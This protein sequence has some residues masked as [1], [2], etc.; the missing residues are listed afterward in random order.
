VPVARPPAGLVFTPRVEGLEDRTL[1]DAG[2]H[3]IQHVIVIMQENHSF[4]S[5]FGTYPGADGIPMQNG[6]PT[7]SV[8]DPVTGQNVMPY[9]NPADSNTGGPHL[10]TDAVN[11]INGGQMD[12][13]IRQFRAN[14]A[15]EGKLMDVMGYHDYHE[16]PNYWAYAQNFVL[17]DHLFAASLGW[18]QPSHLYFVSG[19][20]ASCTDPYQPDT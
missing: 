17:Q 11:D 15:Y 7:V 19:W 12:G 5:Y 16:I 3:T 1:L 8:P 4:D 20:S 2:I 18:S 9:H 13:F 14:A 10:A 6:V